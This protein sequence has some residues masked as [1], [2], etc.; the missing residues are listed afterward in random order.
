MGSESEQVTPAREVAMIPTPGA[1]P[2]TTT[3]AASTWPALPTSRRV[4]A[5]TGMVVPPGKAVTGAN[6][7]SSESGIHQ[8]AM[9]DGRSSFGIMDPA[10]IGRPGSR[11]VPG[12]LSD[13]QSFRKRLEELGIRLDEARL[14][15]AFAQFEEL[16]GRK[17]DVTDEDLE[18]IAGGA[19][20]SVPVTFAL[21]NFQIST[22][23]K[24]VPTA[25]V[26]MKTAAGEE[27][28]EAATGDGPVDAMYH[29]VDRITAVPVTLVDYAL[30]AATSGKDALGQVAVKLE[31]KGHIYSGRGV[32]TDVLEASL[33]A[34]IH[35]LNKI[36]ADGGR[37]TPVVD[38]PGGEGE[39]AV[40][41]PE[42]TR[43]P[44]SGFSA[45]Q[46]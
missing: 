46:L 44:A 40:S 33:R 1:G 17:A 19:I 9:L 12:G 43:R 26:R 24:T 36:M 22:G 45:V 23:N 14:K 31:Y 18:A 8:D 10:A 7:L 5:L 38:T 2:G 16:A 13:C 28:E 27:R 25:R 6:A 32:S 15:V 35:A 41:G 20:V 42:T 37:P 30:N 29:A 34:Y 3:A 39:E 4:S 21:E 11:P